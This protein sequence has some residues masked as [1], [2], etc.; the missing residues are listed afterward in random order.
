MKPPRSNLRRSSIN[1][2]AKRADFSVYAYAAFSYHL[3]KADPLSSDLFILVE[4][5]LKSN[6]LSW[7]EAIAES[8]NLSQLIRTSKNLRTYLSACSVERSPL[9]PRIQGLRGWTTDL[10]RIAAKFSS[11]LIASPSAIYARIPPFCPTESMIYNTVSQ[12]RRLTVLGASSE[13]WDDR[14]SCIDFRQGQPSSLSYGDE[15]IAVG[16]T[17]GAIALYHVASYQEYKVLDHGE[18]LKFITF[19]SKTDLMVTCGMRTIKV[20]DIRSGKVLHN[21]QS[22]Q[23]PL[24]M[25]IDKNTL[26]VASHQNY[27]ASWN[28]EL[29][30]LPKPDRPWSDS[31]TETSTSMHRPPCALTISVSHEILAIAYS[32]QPIMLW[33]LA[34]DAYIGSCGKKLSSGATSTHVVVS[35]AF[36]PNPNIGLLAAAYLDGD[37]ALLDPFSNQQLECFRANCHTLT[38]SPNGRL[39]AAGAGNGTID[40]YEFDTL[41]LLYSVKSSNHYIK[42]ISFTKDSLHLADIRG[43][44]CT[45]WEPPAL[46]RDSLSDDYSGTTSASIVDIVSLDAKVKITTMVVHPLEEVIFCGKDDGAVDLYYCKTAANCRTLYC[47]KSLVRLLSWCQQNDIIMSVD[48]S[49]RIF[50]YKIQK[51]EGKGWLADQMIIFRSHLDSEKAIVNLL[52]G[53]AAG[54]F[55][56]STRESDHLWTLDGHQEAER[57]HLDRPGIRK[58]ILHPKSPLHMIRVDN[59][60]ARI[61]RWSDW[62]E[63]A[64]FPLAMDGGL[65]QLQPKSLNLYQSGQEQRILLELSERDG[66]AKAS[67]LLILDETQ[68]AIGISSNSPEREELSHTDAESGPVLTNR[69]KGVAMMSTSVQLLSSQLNG[70]AHK[71][72]HVIG[73][74]DSGKLIF[75]DHWSWVCSADL[76]THRLELDE[77]LC[78]LDYFRHFFVPYDW[79]AGTRDV[80]CALAQSDLLFVRSSGLA[81]V[82]GCFEYAERIIVD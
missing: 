50:A 77:G 24:G 58:W 78:S 46:L 49:N 60:D 21:L 76:S 2:P 65:A 42:Q 26:L 43:S 81:V 12:G 28:L 53:E 45:V 37:L 64:S 82:R 27:I 66:S 11:A 39:L 61:Y 32:G 40:I 25:A 57:T 51:S 68:L 71:V 48:A 9:N 16:L 35:L 8:Q 13:H 55:V 36:N 15:F 63:V 30:A 19:K 67:G 3:S 56:V 17:T 79:F 31:S 73:I 23:R 62:S 1:M 44:Q 75:L 52:V 33:D 20:W 80:I 47:H 70:L 14:L 29:D 18:T 69:G 54:K 10:I 4:Q 59:S 34:E 5:F 6:V 41:K 7:I 72:A 74:S 22:P 38:V